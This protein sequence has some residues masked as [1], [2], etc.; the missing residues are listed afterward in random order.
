MNQ[1]QFERWA[2]TRQI[3][4]SRFIWRFGVF[5][6]GVPVGVIWAIAMA[7]MRGWDQLPIFLPFA[8]IGFPIGG[9]VFGVWIWKISESKYQKAL[10]D[11]PGQ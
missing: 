3:G 5:A 9:Y 1:K 2:K 7:A 6:W 8:L 10:E 11:K 4:R